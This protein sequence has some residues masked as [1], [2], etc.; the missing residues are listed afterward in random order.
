MRKIL[1]ILLVLCWTVLFGHAE[2]VIPAIRILPEDVIQDS[3]QRVQ[4]DTNK[5]A[6]RWIYTKAGATKMLTFWERHSGEKARSQIGTFETPAGLVTHNNPTY[7]TWKKDWLKHP[8]DKLIGISESEA[9]TIIA[10]LQI[11]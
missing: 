1:I 10:G 2:L 8:T 3:I 6:V 9:K 5:F 7:T 11:R 4:F